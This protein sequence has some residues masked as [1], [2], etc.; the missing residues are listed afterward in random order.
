MPKKLIVTLLLSIPF[1]ACADSGRSLVIAEGP[2]APINEPDTQVINPT[3]SEPGVNDPGGGDPGGSNPGGVPG[4]GSGGSTGGGG[5]GTAGAGNGSGPGNPGSPGGGAG[6]PGGEPGSSGGGGQSGSPVPE[7]A[8][9]LLFGS[10]LAG[11][12]GFS[13]RRRRREKA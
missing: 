7:P 11:L 4:S 5:G 1:A 13:L 3:P 8:T 12:A 10:G 6:A 2:A 9:L